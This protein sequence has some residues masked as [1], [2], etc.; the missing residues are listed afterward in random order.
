MSSVILAILLILLIIFGPHFFPER[1]P[2]PRN[3]VWLGRAILAL[4]VL[5]LI[6]STSVIMIPKDQVGIVT[7][8]YG[9]TA[10]PEGHIMP[11]SEKPGLRLSRFLQ[12]LFACLY[13]STFSIT[14]TRCR[15]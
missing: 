13:S 3:A 15:S 5:Y 9:A 7:K 10:L 11:P 4:L 14:S 8:I 2:V 1:Y 6:V 12:A